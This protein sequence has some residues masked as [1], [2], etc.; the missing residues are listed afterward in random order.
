MELIKKLSAY[1]DEELGD[2]EKYAECAVRLK[3]ERPELAKVFFELSCDEM[4]HKDRLHVEVARLIEAYRKTSGEPP[5]AM[6]ALYD[7]VHERQ[8]AKAREVK[9]LHEMYRGA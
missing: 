2:A 6:L 9:V 5:A 4:G 8:I 7:Y 1:I 3:K